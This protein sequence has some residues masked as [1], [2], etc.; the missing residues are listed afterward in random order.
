MY[1]TCSYNNG[2]NSYHNRHYYLKSVLKYVIYGFP[3]LSQKLMH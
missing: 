1:L 2:H 3:N